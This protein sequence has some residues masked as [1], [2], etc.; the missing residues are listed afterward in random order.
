LELV[1]VRANTN[2]ACC[3]EDNFTWNFFGIFQINSKSLGIFL[4]YS[5]FIPNRIFEIFEIFDK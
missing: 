2:R 4:E 3:L 1:T 5:K